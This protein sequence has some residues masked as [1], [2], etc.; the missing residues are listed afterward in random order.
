MLADS[1]SSSFVSSAISSC[2]WSD[3]GRVYSSLWLFAAAG[4]SLLC[5]YCV[6]KKRHHNHFIVPFG[7]SEYHDAGD[8]V[9]YT[10]PAF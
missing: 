5:S 3:F 6:V 7:I 1:D 9:Y 10:L 8:P 4:T 2:F